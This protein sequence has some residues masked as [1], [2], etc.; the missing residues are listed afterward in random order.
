MISP[1]ASFSPVLAD[2]AGV[3]PL[4]WVVF[5]LAG[6]CW[7]AAS[8]RLGEVSARRAGLAFSLGT[9]VFAVVALV[10]AWAI[11]GLRF[12]FS[13]GVL[14]GSG[15]GYG[16]RAGGLSLLLVFLTGLV[17]PMCLVA[18]WHVP[19][20]RLFNV[21]FLLMQGAASGVFL[22]RNFFLWFLFWELSLFPA[23]FLI[24]LWGGAGSGRAAMTFVLYTIGG[25]AFMLL[26]YAAVYAVAGTWDFE[27]LRG[28]G[29][30]G[31]LDM[32]LAAVGGAA[33]MMVFVGVL[34]G[35]AVKVPLFPF[36]TW[37]PAAYAE[38]PTG[39]AMFL[40]AVMAKMGLYG[41]VVVMAPFGR[42]F[43][44]AAPVLLGLALAGTV[45]GACAAMRQ[46]DLKRMLAYSSV[47]HLGYCLLALFAVAGG[48]GMVSVAVDGAFLQMFNHGLS[49]AALFFCIGVLE[50][51]S[52]VRGL[53]DFGGVRGCAPVFAA[54]CGVALFSS[55][56]LPGLNG[57]VGEFLIFRGLFDIVPWVAAG[58]A[59]GLLGTAVFLLTFWQRVFHGAAGAHTAAVTDLSG[60]E[61]VA[62]VPATVL[63][64]VLG[65]Y[66]Q[67]LLDIVR[68]LP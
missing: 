43:S 46:R 7:L 31:V 59:F 2:F 28:L 17:A 20:A 33:P 36:H 54:L 63:M 49:A 56:G 38:A 21:L 32:R 57:F 58:A 29:A 23:Y 67:V 53:G 50:Q 27:V 41:F 60:R 9:L 62:L 6:A 61:I 51:R 37:L 5:P 52:G 18:S 35:L 24:K 39:V 26:A 55:L 68:L 44:N 22:A 34:L 11:P 4:L 12:E 48:G 14:G 25:S 1:V 16:L 66:P 15:F 47:N 13:P 64:F 10:C 65:V 42:E 40:T 19:R 45:L 30:D 3:V 8:P